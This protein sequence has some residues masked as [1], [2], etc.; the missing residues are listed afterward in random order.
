MSGLLV[1]WSCLRI[2]SWGGSHLSF[3]AKKHIH[4]NK[5][6]IANIVKYKSICFERFNLSSIFLLLPCLLNFIVL[7][8]ITYKF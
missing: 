8:K 4:G 5:F 7:Y 2:R 3:L 6:I 1:E